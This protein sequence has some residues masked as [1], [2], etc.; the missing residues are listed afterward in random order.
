MTFPWTEAAKLASPYA[1]VLALLWILHKLLADVFAFQKTLVELVESVRAVGLAV[2]DE[3]IEEIV[4]LRRQLETFQSEVSR[5]KLELCAGLSLASS[6]AE[7]ML[8]T[9]SDAVGKDLTDIVAQLR[10]LLE[11][12][13]IDGDA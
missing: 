5:E 13:G 8:S 2:R 3:R 1:V 7:K 12:L 9:P 4:G 10:A 11:R 6:Q